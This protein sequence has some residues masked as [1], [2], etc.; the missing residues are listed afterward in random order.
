M[1]RIALQL[2]NFNVICN[3]GTAPPGKNGGTSSRR[4]FYLV[5]CEIP[6]NANAVPTRYIIVQDDNLEN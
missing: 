6:P 3:C 4:E 1:C 5:N 2:E